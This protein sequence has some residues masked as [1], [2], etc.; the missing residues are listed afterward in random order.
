MPLLCTWSPAPGASTC[1]SSPRLTQGAFRDL[2]CPLPLTNV[3]SFFQTLTCTLCKTPRASR[4]SY[5]AL[6]GPL[7]PGVAVYRQRVLSAQLLEGT[8]SLDLLHGKPRSTA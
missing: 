4:L 3:T 8:G 1:V 6:G 2:L 5:P 7:Q